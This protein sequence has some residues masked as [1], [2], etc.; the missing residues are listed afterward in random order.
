M[1]SMYKGTQAD[2]INRKYILMKANSKKN[3]DF[4]NKWMEA[5]GR[6]LSNVTLR[7]SV[8]AEYAQ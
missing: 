2:I 7:R 4:L 5:E 6:F 3:E 1:D 8:R